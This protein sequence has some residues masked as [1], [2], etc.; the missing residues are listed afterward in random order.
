MTR[1]GLKVEELWLSGLIVDTISGATSISSTTVTATNK[2]VS[3]NL[4]LGAGSPYGYGTVIQMTARSNISG[5]MWV[6]ASGG[7]ALAG[8]AA[9]MAPIGVAQPGTNVASG[10]TVNVIVQGIVPMI[11]EGTVAQA[12]G[13]EVG[14]GTGLNCVKP[15]AAGSGAVY[16][17]LDSAASGTASVVFVV[18]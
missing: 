11:A 10:G 16:A 15:H 2:V 8:P 7:L 6:T 3:Q 4:I 14:A 13:V 17:T 1:A 9:A 5:G 12:N 18:L